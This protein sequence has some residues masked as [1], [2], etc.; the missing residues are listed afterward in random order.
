MSP[1]VGTGYGQ[2][3]KRAVHIPRLL[4]A[5][6]GT[7]QRYKVTCH[8]YFLVGDAARVVEERGGPCR[9]LLREPF[10]CDVLNIGDVATSWARMT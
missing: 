4:H 9:T 2:L 5:G 6:L 1:C 10:A 7:N 3:E 8:L